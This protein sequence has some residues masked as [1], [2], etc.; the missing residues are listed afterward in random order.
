[1]IYGTSVLHDADAMRRQAA[2][3]TAIEMRE[4]NA[5][6]GARVW[7]LIKATPA[8][9]DNSLYC[10]LLQSSHFASTCA[11][12]ELDGEI[13]GWVSG[14]IPPSQPDTLFI[15]QVCVG[16]KARGQGLGK[17]LIGHVLGRK[18]CAD[19]DKLECT[20]TEDNDASWGLFTGVARS[21]DAQLQQAE[22]FLHD[23]HFGGRHDSEFAVVIGPFNRERIARLGA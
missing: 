18:S 8:L 9:D 22:H 16:E 20:I 17:R 2:K 21:L 3:K 5:R 6:D 1:M 15:W 19:V 13:V 7:S 23:E 11:I 12:A 4:P 10:N 14:Y